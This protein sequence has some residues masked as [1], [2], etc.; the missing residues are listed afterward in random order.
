MALRDV[1][2]D[3]VDAGAG[4]P[5]QGA[6]GGVTGTGQQQ[7]GGGAATLDGVCEGTGAEPVECEAVQVLDVL[8]V[9]G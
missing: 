5:L 3:R 4:V 7:R 8:D 6:D 2:G 1:P 9:L